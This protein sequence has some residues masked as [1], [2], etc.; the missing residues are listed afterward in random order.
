M[1]LEDSLRAINAF[2]RELKA[3]DVEEHQHAARAQLRA[4]LAQ[5]A[6][7][8]KLPL[9]QYPTLAILYTCSVFYVLVMFAT[10]LARPS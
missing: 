10:S 2:L 7:A 3:N 8:P 5:L 6:S 9:E 4:F 1:S